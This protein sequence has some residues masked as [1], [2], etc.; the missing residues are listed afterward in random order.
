MFFSD[1]LLRN[2]FPLAVM[3]LIIDATVASLTPQLRDADS[4]LSEPPGSTQSS[5]C[6]SIA[7]FVSFGSRICPT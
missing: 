6:C 7:C 5:S 2:D 1:L 3:W 4:T